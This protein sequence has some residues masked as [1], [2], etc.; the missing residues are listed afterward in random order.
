V[1]HE[2]R[3]E[4]LLEAAPEVVFDAF[5]DP[6]AQHELY[7]DAPDWIVK[8]ACDLRVGG[9]WTITFGPPGREPARETNVFEQIDRPRLL[10]YRSTMALPHG[11]SLDT[12]LRVTFEPDGG[13]TRMTIVQSGFPTAELRDEFGSGWA[14]ILDE[15]AR[16]TAARASG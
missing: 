13:K 4:R 5:T 12:Q 7:A 15:L 16:V 14:G 1:T 6:S 9:T 11:S 8:S 3:L 10:V 2:L